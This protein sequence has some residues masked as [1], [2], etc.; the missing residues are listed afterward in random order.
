[1][2]YLYEREL[3][4]SLLTVEELDNLNE[5]EA[6]LI[7]NHFL[8]IYRNDPISHDDSEEAQRL[9]V[10]RLARGYAKLDREME[11]NIKKSDEN[12]EFLKKHAHLLVKKNGDTITLQKS[13]LKDK[14][15]SVTIENKT[16]NFGAKGYSDYTIHKDKERMIRYENRHRAR[17][18]WTKSG[19]KTAGFWAKWLLWNKPS[20]E[21]SIKDT[22]KRFGIKIR[23]IS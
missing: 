1:M 2:N 5:D 18:D 22:E 16:V 14:K 7:L 12:E 8:E 20:L 6:N 9:D 19:I 15:F 21:E 11:E 17:E 10:E 4:D 13:K 23:R 3:I